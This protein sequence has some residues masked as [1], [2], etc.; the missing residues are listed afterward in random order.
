MNIRDEIGKITDRNIH[1]DGDCGWFD[2]RTA[3]NELI[4]LFFSQLAQVVEEERER[5]LENINNIE[6]KFGKEYNKASNCDANYVSGFNTCIDEVKKI[7]I[8]PKEKR[9]NEK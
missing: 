9:T 5:I 4:A 6:K 7:L 1:D 8:Q 3:D 2:E